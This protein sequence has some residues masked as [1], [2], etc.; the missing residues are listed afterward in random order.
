MTVTPDAP[1][2]ARLSWN[3]S[4]DSRTTGY[5]VYHGPAPGNYVQAFGAGLEAGALLTFAVAGLPA[6][7]IRYFAV[8]AIDAGGGESAFSNEASKAID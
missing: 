1:A 4:S 2:V 5:R 6:G 7:D 8:T 3:A